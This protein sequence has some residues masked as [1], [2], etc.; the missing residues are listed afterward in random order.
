MRCDGWYSDPYVTVL[1]CPTAAGAAGVCAATS[2]STLGRDDSGVRS[3]ASLAESG[4]GAGV[5]SEVLGVQSGAASV[6][7]VEAGAATG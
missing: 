3:G 6:R 1:V 7:V 5:R 4:V 2:A